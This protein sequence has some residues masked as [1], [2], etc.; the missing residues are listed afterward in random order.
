MFIYS[1]LS[2]GR[3]SP[4]AMRHRSLIIKLVRPASFAFLPRVRVGYNVEVPFV[5]N[6]H[7]YLSAG[8]DAVEMKERK[9]SCPFPCAITV[10]NR[11]VSRGWWNNDNSKR[12]ATY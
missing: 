1:R 8:D 12:P 10:R 11:S 7:A 4:M 2:A 3:V 5:G 9:P 6:D